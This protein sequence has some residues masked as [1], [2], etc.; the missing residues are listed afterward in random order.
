M[1][2]YDVIQVDIQHGKDVREIR[3][4]ELPPITGVLAA[5]PCTHFARS[6]ARYWKAKDISGITR[7][8]VDLVRYTLDLIRQLDKRD[9]L[10]FWCMEN[11]VG[12]MGELV[13][14]IG[15]VRFK[16][17]PYQFGDGYY[18]RTWLWGKFVPP[19]PLFAGAWYDRPT[20]PTV[21]WTEAQSGGGEKRAAAR[22]ET[23]MGFAYAFYRANSD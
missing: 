11:P 13:P 3:A 18:K 23:P 9:T 19:L 8:A 2:G 12:R 16:F 6:G 1:G 14:E 21:N 10:Q 5:P 17:D 7:E 20:R 4:G 22:S 15:P